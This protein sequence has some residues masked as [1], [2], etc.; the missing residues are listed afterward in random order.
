MS[1]SSSGK[2]L[3]I[4]Y[5][6]CIKADR[7]FYRNVFLLCLSKYTLSPNHHSY[8]GS[9]SFSNSS[10]VINVYLLSNSNTSTLINGCNLLFNAFL[11]LSDFSGASGII[12]LST[13]GKHKLSNILCSL[14]LTTYESANLAW[15]DLTSIS[16]NSS[17][18][19]YL[20]SIAAV[21]NDN[22]FNTLLTYSASSTSSRHYGTNP[23]SKYDFSAYN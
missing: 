14:S 3:V 22:P 5:G 21:S 2:Y 23:F 18:N 20:Y 17:I 16:S 6:S 4:T 19:T 13:P 12:C 1:A 10:N 15:W 9:F 8:S 11:N 7:N